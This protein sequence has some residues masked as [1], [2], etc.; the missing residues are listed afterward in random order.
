MEEIVDLII[1]DQIDFDEVYY[2]CWLDNKS[3]DETIQLK[4]TQLKQFNKQN[5]SEQFFEH[6]FCQQ[7]GLLEHLKFEI[8]N[9]YQSYNILEHY[10]SHPNLFSTQFLFQFTETTIKLM[11]ECYYE[12]NDLI[13]RELLNKRFSK[14]R[15]DFDDISEICKFPVITIR[16][17]FNN[18]KNI[19]TMIE[20]STSQYHQNI[21]SFIENHY[22]LP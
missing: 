14:N 12:L 4:L 9:Y 21:L 1:S 11:L 16:R 13:V 7:N 17:Q 5:Q 15:K 22:I 8:I 2:R 19:S 20:E 10:L 6:L 3:I 18:L